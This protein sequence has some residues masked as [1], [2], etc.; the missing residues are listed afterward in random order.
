M[1]TTTAN[2]PK[3]GEFFILEAGAINGPGHG[4]VFVNLDRLLTPPRL[5]LL[6]EG[7]LSC[8]TGEASIDLQSKQRCSS[9]GFGSWF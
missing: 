4:V 7:G 1:E 6:P 2:Q 3:A 5:I 9:A 8:A